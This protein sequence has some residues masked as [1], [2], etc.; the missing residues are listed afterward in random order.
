MGRHFFWCAALFAS[1]LIGIDSAWAQ[2]EAPRAQSAAPRAQTDGRSLAEP[3]KT[4]AFVP[5]DLRIDTPSGLP[6]PRLVSLKGPK[7]YCRQGPSRSHPVLFTYRRTGLPVVVVAETRDH[8]RKIRDPFGDEC[9]AFHTRLRA[10]SHVLAVEETPL[11]SAA[12]DGATERARI[13]P[14]VLTR[15]EKR[16][17]DWVLIKSG[18]TRGWAQASAFWGVSLE[19]LTGGVPNSG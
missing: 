18:H 8:W 13:A 5:G 3:V 19:Q 17:G 7:D 15:I 4:V 10:R 9:W 1:W 2:S 11:L 6:V 12:K 16:R 14:G